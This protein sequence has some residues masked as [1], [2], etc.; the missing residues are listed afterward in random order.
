MPSTPSTQR[1]RIIVLGYIVRGP[2]GGLA[3]H[4]LQYVMGLA[5]L[6]HDVYFVEDSGDSEWCCYDPVRDVTDTDPA[7]GLQFAAAAFTRVGLGTRWAYY[8]AHA[9]RWCGP[10]AASAPE[11]CA[12]ADVVLNV[13]GVNP[14]RPW[15][16]AIPCRVFVDTDP[17][18]TQIRHLADP[19]ARA[20]AAQHTAFFS[21]GENIGTAGCTVPADGFA[22]QPTR[23]PVVLDAWPVTP[24]PADGKF[25][26]VMQW[27]S[28]PART[29]DGRHYGMKSASFM[30]YLDLPRRLGPIFDLAVGSATAPRDLLREHGWVVRD[31]REPTRDPWT[32]QRYIQTSAAEF[33]VAKH[34]YVVTRSGWFSER[35]AS[36]LASGRPVVAQD[37]GFSQWLDTGTG[38]VPFGTPDEAAAAIDRVRGAYAAQARAARELVEAQFD[39]RT[40]LPR[41]L[42]GA[43]ARPS[44]RGGESESLDRSGRVRQ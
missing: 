16:A 20:L 6:G 8:D 7:Y 1:L 34:G 24:P 3:W 2:L 40:I 31:S 32:Y 21:F 27:D 43:A 28:Y 12:T 36:Y 5:R 18:F 11:V 39:A 38:V 10:A 29:Y 4:H 17:V 41:L 14:L 33:G 25:T 30:P 13:S 19:E 9:R 26:T 37:T 23:Q 15:L 35:S 22:W 42:E 44:G